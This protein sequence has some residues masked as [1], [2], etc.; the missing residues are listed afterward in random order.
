MRDPSL[1]F[2]QIPRNT[3]FFI[4]PATTR[5]P[6]VAVGDSDEIEASVDVGERVD[7]GEDIAGVQ[8]WDDTA[9]GQGINLVA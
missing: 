5:A 7:F 6:A 8:I 9:R 2:F 3:N 1:S 4:V